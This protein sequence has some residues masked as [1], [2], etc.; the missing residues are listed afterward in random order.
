MDGLRSLA[1]DKL[2]GRL[3]QTGLIAGF[4]YGYVVVATAA[5]EKSKFCKWLPP[6]YVQIHGTDTCVLLTGLFKTDYWARSTRREIFVEPARGE[7]GP[8]VKYHVGDLSAERPT[9]RWLLESRAFVKT[10]SMTDLGELST[11]VGVKAQ[12]ETPPR[13]PKDLSNEFN[14]TGERIVLERASVSFN[15][16]SLGYMPSFFD[17]TPSLAYSTLYASE[18][19]AILAAYTHRV[20]GSL[21]LTL[22]LEDGRL[23]ELIDPAWGSYDRSYGFDVVASAKNHFKWGKVQVA[24]AVR[25]IT[26]VARDPCCTAASGDAIG[27]AVMGGVESW[28]DV[29]PVGGELLLNA[30]VARGGL[31]YLGVTNHPAD[32]AVSADNRLF[33]TDARAFV[34]SYAHYWTKKF[35]SIATVSGFSTSLDSDS[36]TWKTDGIHLQGALEYM[37]RK[38]LV[39]GIELNYRD[40]K[41]KDEAAKLASTPWASNRYVVSVV[42]ARHRF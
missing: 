34:V 41:V 16:F 11:W 28:L 37:P 10:S 1:F 17:F 12:S 6:G 26:A 8:E 30:G 40:E 23:R 42:Y 3:G 33:L 32:F 35:R 4:L 31:S 38:G 13:K 22:S 29:G 18:Q 5:E 15:G 14:R 27:W 2:R 39:A 7:R 21:D 9:A 19:N 25:P 20:A 36:L 24:A